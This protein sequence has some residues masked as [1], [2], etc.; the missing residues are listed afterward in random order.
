MFGH[1]VIGA[2]EPPAF[3]LRDAASVR[4]VVRAAHP[5]FVI[6]LAGLSFVPHADPTAIYATNAVGSTNLLE[7]V[8]CEVPNVRKILLAS[9]ANVYG[10]SDG[11]P[12]DEA[13]PPS[14]V[15]H[16]SCSKIAMEFMAQT[17]FRRLP[18]VIA[19]PF[20]YT[21]PGQAEHFLIPKLMTHFVQRAAAI[22]LGNLEVVRDFSDV[23]LVCDAYARL[24]GS[25]VH[26]IALNVCSGVGR[27]VGSILDALVDLA[28]Y[29]PLIRREPEFVRET[30]VHWLVGNNERLRSVIGPLAF[31]D[32]DETLRW[33][34]RAAASNRS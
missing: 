5:D 15:N 31:I 1:E 21:G 19:R 18:I 32:F 13:T 23:R 6:H 7:A 30:E 14:P 4:K 8:A 16:Y 3:D 10:N 24:L 2:G 34:W 12:I 27:S 9:S 20:N 25:P 29:S 33:M 28:G 22:E 11:A 26:S 17:W